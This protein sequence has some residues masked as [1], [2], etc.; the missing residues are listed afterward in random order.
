MFLCCVEILSRFRLK[1]EFLQIFKA[2]PKLG[3]RHC[4][5]VHGLWPNFAKNEKERILHFY[6]FSDTYT[7]SYVV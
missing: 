4:T 1:L 7:C 5:I 6:I 2:A 3:Q